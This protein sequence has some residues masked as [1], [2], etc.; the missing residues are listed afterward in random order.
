M[1]ITPRPAS[2]APTRP[3]EIVDVAL[4]PAEQ[5]VDR[6][7]DQ[8]RRAIDT[9]A[10]TTASVINIVTATMVAVESVG[11]ATGPHKKAL[12]LH[13]IAR[14]LD[15]IPAEDRDAIKAAVLLLAPS[16]IDTVVAATKGQVVINIPGLSADGKCC[17]R[18]GCT[19]S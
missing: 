7:Y 18:P 10:I 12:A 11:T 4:W 16:I 19:I 1:E 13:V 5:L 9:K 8:V 17:G 2:A 15:E 3:A 6:L 14:L